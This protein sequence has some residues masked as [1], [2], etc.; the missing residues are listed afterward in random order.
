MA[1]LSA[2]ALALAL[3]LAVPSGPAAGSGL[4]LQE[5]VNDGAGGHLWNAYN[6]TDDAQGPDIT[7]RP[8]AITYGST[9][10]VFV[11]SDSG[12]LMSWVNDDAGGRLW[13]AYDLS[14]LA[15]DGGPIE[16]TPDA[17][18]NGPSVDV[19]VESSDGGLVEYTNDGANGHLWNAYDLS[20]L[21]SG[22]SAV[23][24][25]PSAVFDTA[26]PVVFVRASNGDL[27]EYSNQAGGS[28]GWVVT[29]VTKSASGGSAVVGD[30][31]AV[32]DAGTFEVFAR[33][34]AGDL[35]QFADAGGIWTATD[36]SETAQGAGSVEG[37]PA[38][39]LFG[40]TT[41]V[42]V[43]GAGGELTEY[44]NDGVDGHAWN[45]YD[46]SVLAGGGSTVQGDP[47]A[48][49]YG[50][51]VHVY[52]QSASGHL[53]EYVNDG[54]GG[55]LWNAYDL[56]Q[57]A[58]DGG[59]I[60]TDPAAVLYGGT[61]VHV[62][63]GG[64]N[65]CPSNLADQ[66]ADTDGAT[67]MITVDSPS[68]ASTT[69]T[70]TVWQLEGGCWQ[71]VFGP[72]SAHVGTAGVSDDKHEGDGTTPTGAFS[73]GATMYG[74]EPNPG[75]SYG[76][77]QLVCGDWWDED[78]SSPEYNTFQHVA[79]GTNP[80]FGGDSEALWETVPAYNYFA[81]IDYNVDPVVPGAGSAIFLHVDTGAPT[82]GCVSIPQGDLVAV[83]DW[84]KPS[85]DPLIV[86]GT[87]AEIRNF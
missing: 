38:A 77:H 42:Y 85:D 25:D 32:F 51:T 46:L 75:V 50:P 36:L 15:G 31:S 60:G 16:G 7:G 63:A 5:Y 52:V 82:A 48:I 76:Y 37:D 17:V 79:C 53:V 47:G 3:A 22:G 34:T 49:V 40:S 83:L 73:I 65:T 43:A 54:D 72:W 4:P 20:T 71:S 57:D 58:G 21:A 59:P 74:V 23:A 11:Q 18:V 81:L 33:S 45:A 69:A 56:S 66:L 84:L 27:V 8:S 30:P 1:A 19:F 29:D 24:G 6:Q 62:Y 61:V 78:P 44:A 55:H 2:P 13:N 26:E 9:V 80:P 70:L 87:D 86:I 68:Y 41:H 12:D 10:Q 64:T 35:V 67:Q 14:V 28:S 39:I